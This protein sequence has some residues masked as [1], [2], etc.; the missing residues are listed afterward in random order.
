M[1]TNSS[2]QHAKV[3]STWA[4]VCASG[5]AID[6]ETIR[7]LTQSVADVLG[8]GRHAGLVAC[9]TPAECITWMKTY[10]PSAQ[11]NRMITPDTKKQKELCRRIGTILK[12]AHPATTGTEV[13]AA[14]AA[15]LQTRAHSMAAE[16]TAMGTALAKEAADAKAMADFLTGAAAKAKEL[17][18]G[19]KGR[20]DCP[21]LKRLEEGLMK[22]ASAYAAAEASLQGANVEE[23]SKRLAGCV[24][25][26]DANVA[27]LAEYKAAWGESWSGKMTAAIDTLPMLFEASA[28][29]AELEGNVTTARAAVAEQAKAVTDLTAQLKKDIKFASV[30]ALVDEAAAGTTESATPTFAAKYAAP[31]VVVAGG[32]LCRQVTRDLWP[33]ALGRVPHGPKAWSRGHP[34]ERRSGPIRERVR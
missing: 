15:L 5:G 26:I 16:A 27:Q 29:M 22:M 24:S 25:V 6:S 23:V 17:V 11:R 33:N 10:F 21:D 12:D 7:D 14:M 4:K 20:A 32:R 28:I 13:C 30:L 34:D 8:L 9:K 18:A 31:A 2:V 1:E 19:A 3:I